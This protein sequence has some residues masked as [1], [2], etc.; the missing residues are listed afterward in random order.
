[1]NIPTICF[2]DKNI[3]IFN[4]DAQEALNLLK[5]NKILHENAEDAVNFLN[6]VEKSSNEWW[7]S[8]KVQKARLCFSKKFC[9]FEKNWA[10]LE[11][12]VKS[13]GVKYHLSHRSKRVCIFLSFI[14]SVPL[15]CD[16]GVR[17]SLHCHFVQ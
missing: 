14:V 8:N 10:L 11:K 5:E 3:Q 15:D 9:C 13:V 2:Y 7:F 6:E 1:M 12:C 16:L 4:E 17:L